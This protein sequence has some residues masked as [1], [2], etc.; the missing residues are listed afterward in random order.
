MKHNLYNNNL[1]TT[2]I[3][4]DT[5]LNFS[6]NKYSPKQIEKQNNDLLNH[7]SETM[8]VKAIPDYISQSSL[9]L[10]KLWCNTPAEINRFIRIILNAKNSVQQEIIVNGFGNKADLDLANEDLQTNVTKWIRSYFDRIRAADSE[11]K[12]RV[13]NVENYLYTTMRNNFNH[14][15]HQQLQQDLQD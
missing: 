6:S 15:I 14:Y 5:Q 7:I 4:N 8:S 1:D 9:A 13:K 11:P 2:K 12:K 10:I 3:H